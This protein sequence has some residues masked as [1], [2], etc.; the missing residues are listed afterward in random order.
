[1]KTRVSSISKLILL[2]PNSFQVRICTPSILNCENIDAC[3][4]H[5]RCFPFT[6]TYLD[7]F[8]S[9]HSLTFSF[10]GST[11]ESRLERSKHST[12]SAQ[13]DTADTGHLL[14]DRVVSFEP[15]ALE[16]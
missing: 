5:L 3:G 9:L 4:F 12:N 10:S 2:S 13:L 7:S 1:M 16:N 14:C 11:H 6:V 15:L 8:P